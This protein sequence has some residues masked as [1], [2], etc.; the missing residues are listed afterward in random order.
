MA[1]WSLI[2]SLCGEQPEVY[3]SP[4]RGV[5]EEAR[6]AVRTVALVGVAAGTLS[7]SFQFKEA[8]TQARSEDFLFA[9]DNYTRTG[10]G[11]SRCGSGDY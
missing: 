4:D 6:R 1:L 9:P 11:A 3:P 10:R 5:A 2:G 8:P 7:L